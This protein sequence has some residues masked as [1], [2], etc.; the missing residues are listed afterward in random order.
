MIACEGIGWLLGR[1]PIVGLLCIACATLSGHACTTGADAVDSCEERVRELTNADIVFDY[2]MGFCRARNGRALGL[3]LFRECKSELFRSL[4][5]S[6]RFIAAHLYLNEFTDFDDY[7][8]MG[9]MK[10][11]DRLCE[12]RE[13]DI[14]SARR[15]VQGQWL[16]WIARHQSPWTELIVIRRREYDRKIDELFRNSS[17]G[18]ATPAPAL[19]ELDDF[20]EPVPRE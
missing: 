15:F 14:S 3:E 4:F 1:T 13:S 8:S 9:S 7:S 18:A 11:L 10:T 19:H 16:G 20:L 12:L 6:G 2:S 5:D 17:P